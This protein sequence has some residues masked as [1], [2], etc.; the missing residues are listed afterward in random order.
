L[1]RCGAFADRT[2]FQTRRP[3]L[4]ELRANGSVLS[5]FSGLA[6]TPLGRE[7][8]EPFISRLDGVPHG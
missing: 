5:F 8:F 2:V 4:A 7:G 3:V 1:G 6:F